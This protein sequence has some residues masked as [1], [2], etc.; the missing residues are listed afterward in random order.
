MGCACCKSEKIDFQDEVELN[1]FNLLRSV[2]KGAFGK[3][4]VVQHKGTQKI[5]ALKYINK[6]KC[7]KMKAVENIIQERRL[8]EE[9]QHP[10]IC[11][12]RF[13]F[14]D[15]ENLFMV[16]DL[17]LGGDLRFHLD[18]MGAL[19]ED[20]VRFY[21]AEIALGLSYL[22]SRRIVHRD[23]K[24]DNGKGFAVLLDEFGHA[25]L[26]D[27]NIAVHYKEEKPLTAVAGSMAYMAPEVLGK[28]GYWNA[29]DWWSLGIMA[30]ELLYGKR[31]FR[32]KTNDGLTHAILHEHLHIPSEPSS[33]P[34][35]KDCLKGFITRNV[36]ERLGSKDSGGEA[37][38]KNH[39]WFSG[40]DWG[41]LEA[42]EIT[43]PF[44]PDSKKANFDATHE[45]EE[46]LLEDNPLKAKPRK[47][48]A[49]G[50]LEPRIPPSGEDPE[51]TRLMNVM[52]D[53]FI[54]FDYTRPKLKSSTLRLTSNN[55][56]DVR[57]S[58]HALAA[59]IGMSAVVGASSHGLN[60]PHGP[61]VGGSHGNLRK[62]GG[63]QIALAPIGGGDEEVED[64]ASLEFDPM[65]GK[66]DAVFL[67]GMTDTGT[68]TGAS[69]RS[70]SLAGPHPGMP[71][72][73]P[74]VAE[75]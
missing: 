70:P 49:E 53:K 73:P 5:Y 75:H 6:A 28:K 16:L 26:T 23:L 46:L 37:R 34:H 19:K 14:Q 2:G 64:D 11:N 27:F 60:A 38:I 59:P 9:A 36:A 52:E 74:S 45:L 39:P 35:A 30:F 15:D 25:S 4:R 65:E 41:K 66:T 32:S 51:V 18:R 56:V 57:L 62:N 68:G 44:V 43:P 12:L 61:A 17:M 42:K 13:A 7:I 10:F 3:V 54:V 29:V 24:P 33:S 47:K 67:A 48:D 8:L 20:M 69:F 50:K 22:H 71:N 55:Q 31:P 40:M 72:V 58:S 63:S 21:V 1:H